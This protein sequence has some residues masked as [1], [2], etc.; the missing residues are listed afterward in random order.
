M[1][2]RNNLSFISLV[3]FFFAAIFFTLFLLLSFWIQNLIKNNLIDNIIEKNNQLSLVVSEKVDTLLIDFEKSLSLLK[4]EKYLNDDFINRLKNN[5][6]Y[7]EKIY[8]LNGEGKIVLSSGDKGDYNFDYSKQEYFTE[9]KNKN[10]RYISKTFISAE[11]YYPTITMS[12]PF[13]EYVIAGFLNLKILSDHIKKIAPKEGDVIG[14]IDSRG[15]FLAHS[16]INVVYRRRNI[17]NLTN[18]KD[19]IK[20]NA[21]NVLIKSSVGKKEYSVSISKLKETDWYALASHDKK[22]LYRP[23]ENIRNSILGII[24]ICAILIIFLGYVLF[25]LLQKEI[26]YLNKFTKL[27][28]D[29]NFSLD[30]KYKGFKEF[31]NLVENFKKMGE[32]IRVQ[33]N[34]IKQNESDLKNALNEKIILL[35]EIHHRVKNNMQIIIS[36]ISL[37]E[38]SIKDKNLI[39]AF[40]EL[41]SRIKA[42]SMVHERLYQT[43]DFSKIEFGDYIVSIVNDL[44]YGFGSLK[45]K[46]ILQSDIE[47]I[48]LSIEQ[49]IPCG[50]I[51]N[52]IV[53]NIYK[54]AFPQDFDK[55]PTIFVEFKKE[56]EE[57]ALLL[58]GDNG[59]GV[60]TNLD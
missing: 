1:S 40:K 5:Y 9:I 50:L 33:E 29:G 57:T 7:I 34:N 48:Y 54:Y 60:K 30:F 58:I 15:F 27:I 32:A 17:F 24:F 28:S 41:K 39:V 51:I 11:T 19:A 4:D 44:Q 46:P 55:T 53:T 38:P 18:L 13:K 59:V 49:A 22:K 31:F 20:K 47:K 8:V 37:Q 25:V 3:L 2:K 35:Q 43:K 21:K 10:E 36:L 56:N 6:D 23:I 45:V 16:D 52:E 12:I 42:M 14:V 26:G